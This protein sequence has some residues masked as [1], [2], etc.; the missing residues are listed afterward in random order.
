MQRGG[1]RQQVEG[2]EDE[3]DFLVADA[4]ELVVVEFADELAVEPVLAFGWG[5]EAA[6]EIHQRRF[7]GAGG[8]HDGDVF[9]V[10]D[11]EVDAAQGMDLLLR[12][13]VVGAPEIFDDDHVA[14]GSGRLLRFHLGYDAVQCHLNLSLF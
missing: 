6:D 14:V 2:L 13:H 5:V 8:A 4:G 12:S 3:S 11:A 9:V 1:A 10:L 7:A